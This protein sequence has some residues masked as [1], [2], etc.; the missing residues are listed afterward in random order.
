MEIDPVSEWLRMAVSHRT[1]V[2][3]PGG[4]IPKVRINSTYGV[5]LLHATCDSCKWNLHLD[6]DK[7]DKTTA[8]LFKNPKFIEQFVTSKDHAYGTGI[9][10]YH[11][12]F[13]VYVVMC[14]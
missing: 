11:K 6:L 5:G 14:S 8:E 9:E 1:R 10:D 2:V 4:K 7:V 13:L 12:L 3:H